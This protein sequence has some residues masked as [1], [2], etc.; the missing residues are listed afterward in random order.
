[1]RTWLVL[2]AAALLTISCRCDSDKKPR[3]SAKSATPLGSASAPT[4][5][6]AAT[7]ATSVS[8]QRTGA[9]VALSA[10]EQRLFVVDE[11]NR[12]LRVARLP[13][14]EAVT[15]P[16]ELPGPPAQVVLAGPLV[17]IT[18]REP[19]LLLIADAE[20]KE[21]ARVSLPTDAWGI[22]VTADAKRAVVTSAW[23]GQVSLVDLAAA[24]VIWSV[25]VPREPRGVVIS[26]DDHAFVS[27]LVGAQLT[28]LDLKAA[29]PSVVRLSLPAAPLRS[30]GDDLDASLGYALTFDEREERL[31]APRH[32][33]GAR[34]KNAWF[35]ASTVDVWLRATREP[36]APRVTERPFGLRSQLS[37][38][39]ISGA[40]ADLVG[41]SLTPFTQPRAVLYRKSTRS[42]LVAGEGDDRIAELDALAVDP[43]LAVLGH[44]QVGKSYHP[45]IQVPAEGGAP[46]GLA[47]TRDERTLYVYCRSTNDVVELGLREPGKG[48]AAITERRRRLALATDPLGPGG[49]TGR[50]LFYNSTDHATSGGLGCAGCH[51]DGRD[52]GHVW[53]EATFVTE[54]GDATI[55]VGAAGNVPPEAHTQGFPRRTPMLAGR[56]T[57]EGPYGW[58]AESPN[59]VDRET[60]GFGLHRWGAVPEQPAADVE[61]RA[62]ALMDFL[63]RGLVPPRTV[64]GAELDET[65][66]RG[67]ALFLSKAVGCAECHT[68][69]SGYTTRQAY[70]LPPLPTRTGFDEEPD[71]KFK[72]PSLRFLAARAPY[73]HDGSAASLEALVEQNANRMGKT[74]QLTPAERA[75]LVAFLRTL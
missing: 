15:N 67:E 16:L 33:L 48:D 8:Q 21:L 9:A 49:A 66:R 53:H 71:A 47:M 11:D 30:A 68:P 29:S 7:T 69:D 39:L 35:G 65:A 40:D 5:P 17:L 64:T 26:G 61:A 41:N 32:A 75:E 44:Y 34:G 38:E 58:H 36:L 14:S 42:L 19:S 25:A 72:I 24:K 20:L 31:F 43:T 18:I 60:R 3:P 62:R 13:L 12:A 46:T 28:E 51:P 23:G 73:F 54:D 56:V 2:S 55:F 6:S 52:D 27:H 70:P 59:I 45:T 22:A 50:K 4:S 63:R 74:T 1:M 10:D 57:A 37:E